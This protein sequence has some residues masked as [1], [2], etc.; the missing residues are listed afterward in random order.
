MVGW[1]VKRHLLLSA[2]FKSR[3]L[4][5]Q[6]LSL[7]SFCLINLIGGAE[8]KKH[9]TTHYQRQKQLSSEGAGENSSNRTG[10]AVAKSERQNCVSFI[11]KGLQQE[12]STSERHRRANDNN[13]NNSNRWTGN[14]RPL[15]LLSNRARQ[16]TRCAGVKA[17]RAITFTPVR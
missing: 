2:L 17:A 8:E 1:Q 4:K 3:D 10:A 7:K 15:C 9:A 6:A 12:R 16:Q 5:A 13:G 11:R 14:R